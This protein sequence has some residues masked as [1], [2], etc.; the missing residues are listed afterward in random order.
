MKNI[1]LHWLQSI[2]ET[3]P[4]SYPFFASHMNSK[5]LP[6]TCFTPGLFR[7][8]EFDVKRTNNDVLDG[9]CSC[10]SKFRKLTIV[11]S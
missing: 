10:F 8:G 4:K 1:S 7:S 2:F 5:G 6:E 11:G 9:D 3:V